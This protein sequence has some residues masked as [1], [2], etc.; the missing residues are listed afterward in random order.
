MS[1]RDTPGELLRGAGGPLRQQ[2]TT[3]RNPP[4]GARP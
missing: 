1:D 4:E 3:Q 2:G